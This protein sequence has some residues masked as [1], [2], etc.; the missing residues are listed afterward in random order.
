MWYRV[1]PPTEEQ[2]MCTVDEIFVMEK[3]THKL[4]LQETQF[5]DKCEKWTEYRRREED[6]TI[7]TE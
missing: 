4:R 2:W 5:E 1:D 7:T 3:I 6:T